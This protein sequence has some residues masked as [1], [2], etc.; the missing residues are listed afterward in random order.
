MIY[1]NNKLF[2]KYLIMINLNKKNNKII[3]ILIKI[4]NKQRR[5]NSQLTLKI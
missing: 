5:L 4:I 3:K 2:I 1:K